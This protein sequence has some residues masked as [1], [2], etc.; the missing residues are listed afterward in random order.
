MPVR[1]TVTALVAASI[2][3]MLSWPRSATYTEPDRGAAAGAAACRG[4]ARTTTQYR[5]NNGGGN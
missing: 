4:F 5:Q 2:T 3:V 1:V